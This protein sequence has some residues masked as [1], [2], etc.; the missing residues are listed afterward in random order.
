MI[1]SNVKASLLEVALKSKRA[2]ILGLGGGGDVIQGIPVAQLFQMLGFEEIYIGG[3][4]CQWW[5]PDGSPQSEVYGVSVLGADALRHSSTQRYGESGTA[6]AIGN[7]QV[8]DWR[9]PAG[10]SG[11]GG[12]FCR[13]NH[14]WLVCW[15]VRLVLVKV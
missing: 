11:V 7:H 5:M 15:V 4:S 2:L 1:E 13:A 3:V 6:I 8:G 14:S 9:M 10:G 12:S